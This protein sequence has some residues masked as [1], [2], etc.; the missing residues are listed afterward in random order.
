MPDQTNRSKTTEQHG[1]VISYFGSTVAVEADNGQIVQCQLHR[2]QELPIVGDEVAW[3]LEKSAAETGVIVR[4]LPRR[5][6][7]A[8]GDEKGNLKKPIAA[9]I[10]DL[11]I[12]MS[13]AP[14]LS[15]YLIDR[16]LIAAELL[17]IKPILVLNK[18][19][20]LND[21]E[22][23]Q[24]YERLEPYRRIGYP[25]IFCSVYAE[26][27][28]DE[29]DAALKDK[30]AVLVGP[31][32]VGK[33]SIISALKQDKDIRIGD[34]SAKGAGKHTTTATRLY[35]L[36]QGGH[37]IDSPGVREFTLWPINK[38]E[39]LQSFPEFTDYA[40]ACKFRDCQHLAEPG[41]AILAAAGDG[42]IG[43]HR[44]ASYQ[45]LMK[46]AEVREQKKYK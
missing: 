12:V 16:Y 36:P 26:K 4:I 40:G 2:N 28:L 17:Q 3:G 21:I 42:R 37:L 8:R 18:T 35:H 32:G 22:R 15:E 1:L 46:Q 31:S 13:P 20:L 11:I 24:T 6:I 14:V 33:S 19:D 45:E 25:V 41:C 9:N 34:V 39:V 10:D 7:L 38:A 5:S 23:Q 27:G 43:K 30:T 44:Y 29:L